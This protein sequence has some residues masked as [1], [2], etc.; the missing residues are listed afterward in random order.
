MILLT[1]PNAFEQ[2]NTTVTPIVHDDDVFHSTIVSKI[3]HKYTYTAILSD[4]LIIATTSDELHAIYKAARILI[5]DLKGTD[6]KRIELVRHVRT[7]SFHIK[8]LI[9]KESID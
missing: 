9:T 7:T 8:N 3:I 6:R 1:V 4:S 2:Y 5:G